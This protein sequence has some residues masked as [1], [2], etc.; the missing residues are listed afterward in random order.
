MLDIKRVTLCSPVFVL[1]GP[2]MRDVSFAVRVS[3]ATLANG[4]E[5]G[6]NIIMTNIVPKVLSHYYEKANGPFRNLSD[7]PRDQAEQVL[8]AIRTA[9][10]SFASK[11]TADYLAIREELEARV[12]RLFIDK[13]GQPKRLRP[14]SMILGKSAWLK[15]W[16]QHGE[17]MSIPLA[18]FDPHTVSFTYGD[19][20]PAMRYQDGKSYRGQVYLMAELEGLIRQFG[21]PQDW[22]A[23]GHLGPDRYIEAQIWD[24]LPLLPFYPDAL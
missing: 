5:R 2:I 15:S 16:Y 4:N 14:H 18:Q 12:R 10:N 17:E 13:G 21:L 1:N 6:Q 9:G 11:R 8:A 22:N 19:L 20:F 7:L 24:D 3:T 23:D